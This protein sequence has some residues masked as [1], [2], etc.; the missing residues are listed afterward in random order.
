MTEPVQDFGSLV[1]P[2]REGPTLLDLF[3]CLPC[4][5]SPVC[6]PVVLCQVAPTTK[7]KVPN[8]YYLPQSTLRG[9]CC[10]LDFIDFVVE[11]GGSATLPFVG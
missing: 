9:C 2:A 8:P 10:G 6:F 7:E 11:A 4:R 1:Q 5:I 3:R